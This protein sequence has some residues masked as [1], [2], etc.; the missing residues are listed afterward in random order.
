[1]VPVASI[2]ENE[3]CVSG[4][5]RYVWPQVSTALHSESSQ[6]GQPLAD[7]ISTKVFQGYPTNYSQALLSDRS[8]AILSAHGVLLVAGGLELS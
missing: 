8:V 5:C 7:S 4:S 3:V 6:V 1:M 2:T